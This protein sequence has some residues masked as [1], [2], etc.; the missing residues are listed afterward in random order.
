MVTNQ[1]YSSTYTDSTAV[2]PALGN[3]KV[4]KYKQEILQAQAA[5]IDGWAL[6]C[7]GWLNESGNNHYYIWYS[8]QIF[9]AAYELNNGFKLFFSCDTCCGNGVNDAEDMVRRFAND[10]HWGQVYFKYN[11]KTVL[12][13][14]D[15]SQIGPSGMNQIRSDLANGTNPIPAPSGYSASSTAP[16]NVLL[17]PSPFWGGEVPQ[18][19]AIQSQETSWGNSIDGNLYWGIAGVPGSGGTPDNPG[20]DTIIGSENMASVVHGASHIYIAPICFHFWGANASRYFDYSGYEGYRKYWMDAI[21]VTHPEMVEIITWNDFMEGSYISPMDDPMNYPLATFLV[22]SNVQTWRTASG[23]PLAYWHSHK[24]VCDLTK[25][26][27]DWYKNGAEDA[28]N[29]DSIYWAYRSQPIAT[30]VGTPTIGTTY[31]PFADKIYVT[32][33]LAAPATLTVNSAGTVTTVNVAAGSTDVEVPLSAGAAPTFTL[34]RN[35]TTVLSG[36]GDSQ[37]MTTPIFTDNS[38]TVGGGD[39]GSHTS[40]FNDLYMVTG[41]VGPVPFNQA[42][43]A[44]SNLTAAGAPAG[45]EVDLNWTASI[46]SPTISYSIYRGTSPGGESTTAL[47]TTTSTSYADKTAVNGTK[48]YYIVKASNSLGTSPASN[49][50]S[51]TPVAPTPASIPTGLTATG[52]QKSVSLTWSASTGTSPITYNILRS[53]SSGAETTIKTGV[54]GTSFTDTGLADGTTY[55]YKVS[56]TNITGTSGNSSE[57]SAKTLTMVYQIDC[58]SASAVA[59]FAADEFFDVGTEYNVGSVAIDTSQV[60]NPAPQAV[61]QTVRW[62]SSFNYTIP[63]L[64]AGSNYLVRLHFCELSFTAAG[65]R[66]FNVAINGSTVLSAFDVF[67]AA[68]GQYRAIEKDFNATANSS[69]QILIAFSQG[70]ADNPDVA[71]IEIYGGAGVTQNPPS[72]PTGLSASAGNSQVSLSWNASSGATSYNVYRGTTAGGEGATPIAT[73]L[74]GTSYTNTGLTNGTTYYYK[75]AAVNAAGTSGMSNE[76][77]ATPQTSLPGAPTGLAA[78]AGNA[79]VSLSWTGSSGA[80][81]YNVYRGTTA[82][83][84]STTAIATGIT[85]T[86]YTNTGLTNGTTYYYKVAAVNSA[87]TSG[88]SN[89]ASATPAGSTGEGPYGGTPWAI[90]GTVQA[91]NFDTGGEGVAYHDTDAANNG[92][93]YRTSEGVDIETC[94]DTGGG[95]DEGWNMAGEWQ[96]YTVNVASAGTYTVTFRVANGTTANGSFHLQDASGTNLTGTVTVAPTGG[97]QTWTNVTANVT[98]PAGQQILTVWDD[99]SNYNLNYMTFTAASGGQPDLIVTSISWTPSPIASDNHVVFSCVVKNQGTAATPAGTIVGVQF[100]VDGVTSP[101]TWSDT[102]TNSLAP[103]ASVTLTANN[104]TNGVNYWPATSGSHTVQAWV[105]DVNRIAESNENNN[106]L[107]ANFSVP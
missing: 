37:V 8:E 88:M 79:Q 104:G 47:A 89:E 49:E 10:P 96:K 95:Y 36:T 60:A 25:F 26:F 32:C 54:T 14:F 84:E 98:L 22:G 91:E 9:E 103:G 55:Y 20:L 87:G 85:G 73:G 16:I 19:P 66:K 64:T 27:V 92:G 23:P 65:S 51:A 43:N 59:P 1:D 35:G 52:S 30:N 57:A 70:G 6:N 41:D 29:S 38:T 46:G 72:A 7:G 2:F 80:T 94:S 68:G 17:L 5:G 45:A 69:G 18:L 93:Q 99:G 86:T 61:Y 34:T 33:N 11:N 24:G 63:G 12:S 40:S 74:T 81:S 50:A 75:V 3:D 21:N 77:S 78:S 76:A 28:I 90:P 62:N 83:G 82:G 102:D 107:T 44:P 4:A 53:T 56:A 106:K 31:G 105:D 39:G 48:Y 42:P 101:I 15:G 67:A 58:G 97:W 71:A 13:F 100:A